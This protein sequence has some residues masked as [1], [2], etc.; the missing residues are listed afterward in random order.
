MPMTKP[1]SEQV[2]FLAV[3]DDVANDTVAITNS[4]IVP[5]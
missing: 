1:T 3:G 2:T 5:S 4:I